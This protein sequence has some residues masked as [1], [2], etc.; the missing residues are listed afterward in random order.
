MKK[1]IL[2]IA[3]IS[4]S[5]YSM[6]FNTVEVQFERMTSVHRI[7]C[8]A[9]FG[10]NL[11]RDERE[12]TV[13]KNHSLNSNAHDAIEFDHKEATVK[14]CDFNLIDQLVIDS[15]NHFGHVQATFTVSKSTGKSPRVVFGKCQRNYQEKVEVDLGRGVVLTTST[16]GKLIP[17][18]GCR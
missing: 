12:S 8:V 5:A 13:L 11:P 17:A 1:L 4:G 9:F 7:S 14:G 2:L 16:L 15:F 3:L 18:T 6:E 10:S